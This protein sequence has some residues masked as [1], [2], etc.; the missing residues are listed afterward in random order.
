MQRIGHQIDRVV[1][2]GEIVHEFGNILMT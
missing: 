2:P 1:L